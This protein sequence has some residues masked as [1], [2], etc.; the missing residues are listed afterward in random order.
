MD[1]AS[2]SVTA[3]FTPEIEPKKIRLGF[4]W[5][6]LAAS[7]CNNKFRLQHKISAYFVIKSKTEKDQNGESSKDPQHCLAAS[8]VRISAGS[9]YIRKRITISGLKC[10]GEEKT[11]YDETF[12]SDRA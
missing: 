2:A 5:N 1:W 9:S 6:L 11:I 12:T 7:T 8:S 3:I 4:G 10:E